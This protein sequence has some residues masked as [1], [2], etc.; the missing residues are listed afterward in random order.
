LVIFAVN[1]MVSPAPTAFCGR[2][3]VTVPTS[4]GA[5]PLPPTGVQSMPSFF[6]ASTMRDCSSASFLSK[7]VF[8]DASTSRRFQPLACDTRSR[9]KSTS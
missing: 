5:G 2:S 4:V 1:L 9:A 7:K 3:V 8:D 6:S